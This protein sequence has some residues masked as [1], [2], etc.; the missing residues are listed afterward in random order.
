M[1]TNQQAHYD[2]ELD[3]LYVIGG[4]GWN[5]DGSD[6][7]TFPTMTVIPVAAMVRAVRSNDA[8]AVQSLIRT[9]TDQRFAVTGGELRRIG[10]DFYLVFGQRF[11]GQY[12]AFGPDSA[13]E[14]PFRQTYTNEVRRFRLNPRD[15]VSILTY[16]QITTADPT[17]PFHRRDGNIFDD[18]DPRTGAARIAVYGGV[19]PPGVIDAYRQPIYIDGT[20]ARVEAAFEQRF[21][22]YTAPVIVTWDSVGGAV[23]RTFFGGI[24][25]TYYFQ[26]AGQAWAMDTVTKQGR[27]DGLPFTA[28]IT[29][30]VQ[31]AAGYTE[32]ILPDPVPDTL[33]L[34]A[35]VPFI[36]NTALAASGRLDARGVVRLDAFAAGD[37]A[38]IGYIYGGILANC[39]LPLIPSSGT[40]ASNL[41]FRVLLRKTASA[42]IPAA[43]GKPALGTTGHFDRSSSAPGI[44]PPAAAARAGTIPAANALC[45]APQ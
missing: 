21:S 11:D 10:S 5:A 36:P 8:Q 31:N 17:M 19:F 40:Q 37:S 27:N 6:M 18:V 12:R 24:G 16:T 9:V 3:L 22:Q 42:A 13:T 33:L 30:V 2:A 14:L 7:I 28:D 38:T 39:P 45:P 15:T 1:A 41:L 29:T 25:G 34:A 4:Y 44:T 32:W 35:T 26:A 20:G 23:Y 43:E